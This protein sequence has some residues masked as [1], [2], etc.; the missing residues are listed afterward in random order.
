M[1]IMPPAPGRFSTSTGCPM[2]SL[3][4]GAMMRPMMSIVLP[5]AK[6]ATIRI[7]LS[8]YVCALS[9]GA[10]AAHPRRTSATLHLRYGFRATMS[11][12]RLHTNGRSA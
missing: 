11:L 9:E 3:S 7:G 6:G 10:Q 8:G 4:F 5:G 12:P 1:P 2:A